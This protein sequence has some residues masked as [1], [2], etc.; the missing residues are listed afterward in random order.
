MSWQIT[1][2]GVPIRPKYAH[3]SGARSA[4]HWRLALGRRSAFVKKSSH[5][6]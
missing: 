5:I 1:I 4:A 2:L 3:Y 6:P